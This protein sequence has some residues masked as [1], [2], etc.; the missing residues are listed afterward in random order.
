VLTIEELTALIPSDPQQ[1]VIDESACI[2]CTKCL[3]ACPVDAIIGSS[4]LLHTVL[5]EQCIGCQLCV[6]A[7]PVDCI[8]MRPASRKPDLLSAQ[9]Q[10]QAHDIRLA[11][12]QETQLQP[13]KTLWEDKKAYLAAALSRVRKL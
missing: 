2:G 6:A 3:P 8:V 5:T 12:E 4:K 1:A 10:H 9:H 7:C 13:L 11:H